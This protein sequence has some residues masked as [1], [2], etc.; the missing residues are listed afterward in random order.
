VGKRK[1]EEMKMHDQ[2]QLRIET[3]YSLK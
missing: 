1:R 3:K 2:P